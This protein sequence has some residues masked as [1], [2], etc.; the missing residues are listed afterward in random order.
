MILLAQI[1]T[2]SPRPIVVFLP[3]VMVGVY[4]ASIIYHWL[5][6]N[7]FWH[8]IDHQ[9]IVMLTGLTFIPYWT[10]L[11]PASE[12]V[13]RMPVL[14]GATALVSAFRWR[15][16]SL[17]RVG[18]VLYLLLA[19]FPLTTS[20]FELQVWLPPLGWLEFWL[21]ILCYGINFVIH[22]SMK[23]DP[24]PGLFGHGEVQHIFVVLGITLQA[25]VALRYL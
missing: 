2:F 21:G 16:F 10:T 12:I 7:R 13:W 4:S 8:K 15:W 6:Y 22:T 24:W 18:G 11:L 19:A 3:V 25:D 14:L 17:S 5:P 20:F 23:P 9:M 1:S